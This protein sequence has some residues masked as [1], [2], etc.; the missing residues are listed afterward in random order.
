MIEAK[1]VPFFG[2]FS[3]KREGWPPLF[4]LC[5]AL[6]KKKTLITITSTQ[7]EDK[8]GDPIFLL[9]FLNVLYMADTCAKFKKS[10]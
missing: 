3:M 4:Y 8:H 10:G 1:I 5:F 6:A 2:Q 9:Q 7:W